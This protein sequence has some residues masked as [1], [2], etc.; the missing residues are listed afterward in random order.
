MVLL[1]ISEFTT[2]PRT[3]EQDL[4]SYA[5]TGVDALKVV[6]AKL[7]QALAAIEDARRNR[8]GSAARRRRRAD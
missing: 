7:D 5:R 2:M 4:A 6:E 3:F 8:P 1:G